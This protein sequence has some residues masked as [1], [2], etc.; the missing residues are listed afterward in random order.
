MDSIADPDYDGGG[1]N[2][3]SYNA[4]RISAPHLAGFRGPVESVYVEYLDP[5]HEL[6][7]SNISKDPYEIDNVADTFPAPILTSQRAYRLTR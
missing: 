2:P 4:V 6:E 7:Y 1:S 3:T 5:S